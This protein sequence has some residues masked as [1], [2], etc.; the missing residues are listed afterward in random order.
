MKRD[1]PGRRAAL[2][3]IPGAGRVDQDA[4]HQPAGHGEEVGAIL[5]RHGTQVDQA[6]ERLVDERRRLQ[7]M[8][9]ALAAHVPASQPLQFSLDH[10]GELLE[11]LGAARSPSA[12][13][14]SDLVGAD[15]FAGVGHAQDYCTPAVAG[16]TCRGVRDRIRWLAMSEP[17]APRLSDLFHEALARPPAD[18]PAFLA[19]ACQGDEQLRRDV[20]AL[21]AYEAAGSAMFAEPA[22]FRTAT[23]SD[24]AGRRLGDYVVAE[25]IGSGG[26]GDVYRAHD[27]TLARDVALKVLPPLLAA[28]PDRIAR[29]A[30][31]ARVLAAVAHP[32]IAVVHGFEEH[33]GVRILVMEL[34]SGETLADRLERGPVPPNEA[35]AIAVQIADAL[36]AAHGKGI[37]H[38]DLKPANV[39]VLPD[40]TVKVLDFGL[41]KVADGHGPDDGH[42]RHSTAPGLIAGT[43]AYMSPEQARGKP[44]DRRTDVWAFGCVLYE[45]LTGQ[46]AFD[47]ATPAD[48]MAA[49]LEREPDWT[50]LPSGLPPG[51][52]QVLRRCL[53]KDPARRLR[54]MGDVRILMEDEA[55]A[56]G[57]AEAPLARRRSRAWRAAGI[58]ALLAGT[59]AA[60]VVLWPRAEP[61]PA[62]VRVSVATPGTLTP[63][64]SAA[65]SPGGDR[66]A[67]VSTDASGRSMLWVRTMDQLEPRAV[68]GTERAAHPFWSPDGESLGF[69]ADGRIKRVDLAGGPV[70]TVTDAGSVSRTGPAWG[71]DGTILF[72]TPEGHLAAVNAAGGPVSTLRVPERAAGQTAF[73]W[74][75]FL[76]DGR[77]YLYFAQDR[78]PEARGIYVGSLDSPEATFVMASDFRAWYASPGF[79]IYPRDELLMAQPF[80]AERGMLTGEPSAIA[81]GVWFARGA[82]QAAFS[83]SETGVLAYVNAALW[84]AD[85]TWFDRGGGSLGPTGSTDRYGMLPQ[86]SPDGRRVAIGRGEFQ[87]EDAW[88]ADLD[89]GAWSRVTFTSAGDGSLAWSADGRRLMHGTGT[90]VL[91]VDLATGEESVIVDDEPG[92]LAD[93]SRDGR[94]ALL[95]RAGASVDLWI[96][97]LGTGGR[98][99]RYLSSPANETQAQISPDGRW[100]AYTANESGR[101]EVYL[102]SFPVPGRKRQ[103]SNQG[104][105]MPRWRQDG[106]ELFYLAADQVL[107]AVSIDGDSSIDLGPPQPLFRTK[108]IVQGSEATTLPTTYAVSPDGQRFLLRAPPDDPPPAITVVLNWS[109]AV[110]R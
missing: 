25:R 34:V 95:E 45:L 42:D 55:G 75:R 94:Y 66:V 23:S 27:H 28:D 58:V 12:E 61:R 56:A 65:I 49:V 77:R 64:M 50:R 8:T 37:V 63:Q 101:D 105:V 4:P 31:E 53:E 106:R 52:R 76:P 38:R 110:T 80:D 69:I 10:R 54:D 91:T 51:I 107:T 74:P 1:L 89:S 33:D 17:S 13:Q 60:A 18:R 93:V 109:S 100:V 92:R 62:V 84:D 90:R 6:K 5:P 22:G 41:A 24:L 86:V 97:D 73:L 68:A 48:T 81:D 82:A 98:P 21:L 59:I 99:E 108:L 9:G 57:E 87:R 70:V 104:G 15:R 14:V 40:G 32:H 71:R 88:V 30:Q 3:G 46:R 39:K 47:A 29:F 102:Q 43:P 36:E 83:V 11:G 35:A 20:E 79:L 2:F 44:L 16:L 19:S 103:V 7:R 26:M 85:L 67:F 96:V 78:R 72:T